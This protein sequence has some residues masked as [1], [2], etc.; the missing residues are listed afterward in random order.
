MSG[1]QRQRVALARALAK[2]PKV[3]IADEPT[4]NL[5][6]VTGSE[7]LKLLIMLSRESGCSVVMASHDKQAIEASDRLIF[8]K[9]GELTEDT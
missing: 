6:S 8:L 1:G 5:D 3:L 9:D 7:I 2:R 4:A